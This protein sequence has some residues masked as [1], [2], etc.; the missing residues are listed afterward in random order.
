MRSGEAA[1][2]QPPAFDEAYGL[3][4]M[5]G[6]LRLFHEVPQLAVHRIAIKTEDSCRRLFSV[7]SL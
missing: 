3:L 2:G 7:M 4:V 1:R 6:R 5:V